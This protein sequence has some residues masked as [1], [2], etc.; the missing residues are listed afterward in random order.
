M[1]RQAWIRVTA[2]AALLGALAWMIKWAAIMA[3]GASGSPVDIAAFFVGLVLVAVGSVSLTLRLTRGRS[4]GV[5]TAAA[6][7]GAVLAVLLVPGL[8]IVSSAI[9][10]EGTVAGGEG[11]IAVLVVV[12]LL[13]GATGLRTTTPATPVPA[14]APVR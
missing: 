9:F 5:T 14:G 12:A 7:G 8:S 6:I 2:G 1:D 11:G 13:V 10:G 3:Q 4:R